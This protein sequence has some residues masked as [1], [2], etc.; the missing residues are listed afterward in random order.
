MADGDHSI[1]ELVRAGALADF[2]IEQ[3]TPIRKQED[4]VDYLQKNHSGDGA[5]MYTRG[6]VRRV[7]L[8]NNHANLLSRMGEDG[9]YRLV[10]KDFVSEDGSVHVRGNLNHTKTLAALAGPQAV[11]YLEGFQVR[12]SAYGNTGMGAVVHTNK[13]GVVEMFHFRYEADAKHP[14]VNVESGGGIVGVYRRFRR[15]KNDELICYMERIIDEEHREIPVPRYRRENFGNRS[16]SNSSR[17]HSPRRPANLYDRGLWRKKNG[18]I[19]NFS[20][21]GRKTVFE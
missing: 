17:G 8:M 10:P 2:G 12:R 16:P 20:C 9:V 6:G 4:L 11:K 14:L 15:D 18:Y 21:L 3:Q 19:Y 5:F 7:A 1:K 13:D